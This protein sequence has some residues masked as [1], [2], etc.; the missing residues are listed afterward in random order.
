LKIKILNMYDQSSCIHCTNSQLEVPFV[1][2]IRHMQSL[3][4]RVAHS[5]QRL[6]HELD[7]QGIWV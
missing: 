6:G 2:F 5:E 1:L 7:D 3:G 4:A